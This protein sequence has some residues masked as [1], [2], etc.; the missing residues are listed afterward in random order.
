MLITVSPP[1][2]LY[3]HSCLFVDSITEN[4]LKRSARQLGGMRPGPGNK[5]LNF[6][7]DPKETVFCEVWFMVFNIGRRGLLLCN[8][9]CRTAEMNY[10]SKKQN[11]KH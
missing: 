8:D 10:K 3:P 7:A 5:C 9:I 4:E 2:M 11:K 1:R 6:R